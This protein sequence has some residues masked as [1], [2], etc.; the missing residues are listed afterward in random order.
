MAS[1]HGNMYLN[2]MQRNNLTKCAKFFIWQHQEKPSILPKFAIWR[3][4]TFQKEQRNGGSLGE[5]GHE[6]KAHSFAHIWQRQ[7]VMLAVWC[8][9]YEKLQRVTD[10]D[11][12][13]FNSVIS[14]VVLAV[15][16]PCPV[17]GNAVWNIMFRR[18]H[19]KKYCVWARGYSVVH[20]VCKYCNL[21]NSQGHNRIPHCWRSVCK[22]VNVSHH[23]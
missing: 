8:W 10:I 15:P 3:K 7:W 21:L 5:I 12:G 14:G 11:D 20:S 1:D 19:L 17:S 13:K 22:L 18:G 6:E 9:L 23:K 4:P 2:K 16:A